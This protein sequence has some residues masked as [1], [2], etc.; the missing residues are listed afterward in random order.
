MV[1]VDE[2]DEGL[3]VLMKVDIFDKVNSTFRDS[4]AKVSC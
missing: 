2:V 1:R 3:W 4:T